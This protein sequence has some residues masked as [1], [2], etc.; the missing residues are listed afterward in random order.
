MHPPPINPEKSRRFFS[1]QWAVMLS[2]FLSLVI[3]S[4]F[5]YF[6]ERQQAEAWARSELEQDLQRT[7]NVLSN[8]LASPLWE[9]S[10]PAAEAIVSAM[11]QD[12]RFAS[13]TVTE[14]S[15]KNTF[16]EIHRI[17][18]EL[19]DSVEGSMLISRDNQEIGR[20]RVVMM[21]AP[22]LDAA[23]QRQQRN[24]ILIAIALVISLTAILLTLRLKLLKPIT[25]LSFEARRIADENLSAPIA[26]TDN[27]ELGKVASAMEYMRR[28][29]LETFGEL[30]DKNR[31]LS[32]Y[33]QTLESRV[34]ERTRELQQAL[35]SL[36]TTQS[37]LVEA[38]KLASLGRLVAGVA[39]ELNT[40]IGNGVTLISTLQA[41]DSEL[42]AML[43][44]G[45]LRRSTL[46]SMVERLHDGHLIAFRNL[47]R[48]AEIIRNFKQLAIDQTTDMRRQFNLATL[49]EEVLTSI[50]PSF[51]PTSHRIETDLADN[52]QM[53]S[54]P[55]PLGQVL[56][57]IA[58]NALNHGFEGR[59][60]GILR[61]QC[62]AKGP[63][64]VQIDCIDDG[65]GIDESIRSK[66][67]DPFFTTK[68]GQGGSGLGL[69][70]S[71][72]IVTGLLGGSLQVTSE[73][74]QGSTFTILI[75]TSAP[76]SAPV[77]Q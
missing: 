59:T 14:A 25:D 6:I 3:P 66:I 24:L 43:N 67:F 4:S 16:V 35:D 64:M 12:A 13:I 19:K 70:I 63:D 71:Y 52:L 17:V 20:V 55:G 60:G 32:E 42:E 40:P 50:Q 26:F 21:L 48:A 77:E 72:S 74:G 69:H 41:I 49:I 22:Y 53:D 31:Q 28:R 56:T 34:N 68:L 36:R 51:K 61:I 1:L 62:R 57:N 39:H 38:E 45:T 54:F 29:L 73:S 15:N 33:A 47:Q 44:A 7:L 75:P 11:I 37:S 30:Q 23:N 46:N 8:S 65:I 5:G 2:V 27:G 58:L 18:G 9:L 76:A 10:T